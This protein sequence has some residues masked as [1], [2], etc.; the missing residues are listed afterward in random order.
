MIKVY[1]WGHFSTSQSMYSEMP[2]SM[3]HEKNYILCRDI[4]NEIKDH[5]VT[6][7]K[8]YS[9]SNFSN[10]VLLITMTSLSFIIRHRAIS[11]FIPIQLD[12]L[13]TTIVYFSRLRFGYNLLP[14][15]L[16]FLSFNSSPFCTLHTRIPLTT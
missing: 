1:Y 14:F 3:I 5:L 2:V 13:R 11:S 15:H 8:S 7:M 10:L 4:R 16:F 6:S 12:L 9:S